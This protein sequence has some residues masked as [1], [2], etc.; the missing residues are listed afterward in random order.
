MSIAALQ[1]ALRRRGYD[2]G[3]PDGAWGPRTR[4]ALRLFQVAARLPADG[5]PGPATRA[6]LGLGTEPDGALWMDVAERLLGTREAP[7]AAS[8]ATVLGWA[9]RLGGATEAAYTADSIPWCGLF[10][11]HCVATALPDEPLPA[12]PL[13]ARAWARFGVPLARPAPGAICVFARDGGGHVGFHAG[14]DPARGAIRVLGGNQSDAVTY[15]TIA[16]SRL[17]ALRW[18]RT[19]APPRARAALVRADGALSTDEA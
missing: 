17:V 7:G 6:A 19:A 3:P 2:P 5:V 8:S 13:R 15:A 11:A 1:A 4:T 10:V 18:P 12:T 16:A 14:S 9:E